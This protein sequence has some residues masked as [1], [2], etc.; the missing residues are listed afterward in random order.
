MPSFSAAGI[1]RHDA[2]FALLCVL[3]V[4]AVLL[5]QV[6]SLVIFDATGLDRYV[7]GAV[8]YTVVPAAL[9]TAVPALAAARLYDGRRMLWY[10]LGV[11]VAA[12]AA[13]VLTTG[14]FLIG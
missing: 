9:V 6:A 5:G 3:S 7:P 12:L 2:G 10:S 4:A 14:F 13:A 11:F 8:L 1:G